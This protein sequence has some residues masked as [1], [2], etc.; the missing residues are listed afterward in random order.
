MIKL[1]P[2]GSSG[3]GNVEGVRLVRKLN[4]DAMEVEFTYGVRMG[5]DAAKELGDEAK[6]L[7]IKLSVHAPYY[8]NLA[9]SDKAKQKASEKRILDS[10]ER[11]HHFG[12]KQE[13]T[14]VVFH[15]GFYQGRDKEEIY[16]LIK[17]SVEEMQETIKKKGWNVLLCPETTGKSSQFGDIDELLRLS[18]ETKCGITVDFAHLMAR[19]NG[20]LDYKELMEKLKNLK[21]VHCHFSGIEYTAKG[22]R[23][24]L[25][26]DKK[27]IKELLAWLK[28]YK[29]DATIINESPD[30][31]GDS[32]KAKELR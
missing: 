13:L 1:G 32:L 6:K 5:I 2:A 3:L 8:V 11:A 12:T 4:L 23:R 16:Q 19:A 14:P 31:V 7:G 25:V 27:D 28:K 26:T 21:H 15:A 9:S 17:K 24:H 30:P 20:K 18:H 10:C 29:I 22:E